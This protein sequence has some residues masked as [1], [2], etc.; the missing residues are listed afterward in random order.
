VLDSIRPIA[1]EA[2]V[3]LEMDAVTIS[4]SVDPVRISQVLT[5]L[6]GNAIKFSPMGGCVAVSVSAADGRALISIRDEGRGI[7]AEQIESV[8]DR[9]HQVDRSDAR[10]RGGTGL[11]LAISRQI[12]MQ[13]GGRIW[14]ES[15]VGTGSTFFVA[16]PLEIAAIA[17]A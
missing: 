10:Q 16:L 13:H 8:F 17:A 5:N 7:P 4:A 3:R 9:F 1:E 12:V 14:A 6:V 11:G 2:G 15:A